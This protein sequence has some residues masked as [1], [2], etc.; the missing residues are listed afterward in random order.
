MRT[1]KLFFFIFLFGIN[2]YAQN[3]DTKVLTDI[4]SS[5]HNNALDRVAQ[6]ALTHNG[7]ND[8]SKNWSNEP[9]DHFFKYRVKV[10]GITDQKRSGRCWLFTSLNIFRPTA[11]ELFNVANFEFSQVYL[12]FWDLFEKSNLF[13]N[14]II[15]TRDKTIDSRLVQWYFRE[16]ISDGGAWNDF[17][18]LVDKY[19]LVPKEIMPETHSSN[20]T[21]QMNKFIN[22]KLR[23]DA[24]RLREMHAGGAS[25]EQ[26]Q[27]KKVAMLKEVYRMLVLNLGN[28]PT[29]FEWRYVDNA[30]KLSDFQ[31]YTPLSF[32]EK[33][34]KGANMSDYIMIMN[35]PTRPYDVHYEV[36]NYRNVEEGVNWH[37]VNLSNEDIKPM[38]IA[39]I[40]NNEALY[41]SCDVGKQHDREFG[42]L[43]LNNYDYESIYGVSFGMNKSDR[44]KTLASSSAHGM[45]LIAVDVDKDGNPTKWQFENSWGASAGHD[46][47]LSFTDK[48]FDEYVFRIVVHKK[49]VPSKILKIHEKK[50]KLLFPWDWMG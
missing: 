24:I 19:G 11:I 4:R 37:Y 27:E 36:D 18:N 45:L 2:L 35:D 30:G 50:A 1:T 8:I 42:F 33:I 32:K 22:L 6:N 17:S 47:Y 48:W 9:N 46:G 12:S 15:E 40:K 44:I 28:P 29:E 3:I 49:Y 23:E 41:V 14:N 31:H 5:Y 7:I 34:L 10:K 38:L 43:D 25:L 39:S 26:L 16:P 21:R 20:N 13:L